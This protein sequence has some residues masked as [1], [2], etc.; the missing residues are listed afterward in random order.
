M[1][2]IIISMSI[3]LAWAASLSAQITREQADEIVLSHIQSA[4]E[5]SGLLYSNVNAPDEAGIAVTTSNGETFKAKYACWAYYLNENSGQGES[6]QLRYF[7]VKEDN[8]S[9][10]E[11]ITNNDPGPGESTTWRAMNIPTGLT[12]SGE[13]N[14]KLL[15]PNPVGDLLIIPCNDDQARVEIYDLKGTCLFSGMLPGEDACQLNVSFLS[16]GIYMVNVSGEMYK[17]IKK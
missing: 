6:S 14:I 3:L 4:T 9:L 13:N 7:F 2:K 11:V 12:G 15:Y 5:Q 1:K 8:G 17:M 10:L 16:A